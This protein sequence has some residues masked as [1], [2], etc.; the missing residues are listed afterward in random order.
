MVAVALALA[1]AGCT[2]SDEHA[3]NLTAGTPTEQVEAI[4]YFTESEPPG[5]VRS[6]FRELLL[7]VAEGAP[8]G[9]GRSAALQVMGEKKDPAFLEALLSALED[10]SFIVRYRAAEALGKYGDPAAVEPLAQ[11]LED[12]RHDW[13]RMEAAQA[14]T[15][16]GDH[17]AIE[18]LIHALDED[19]P[20]PVRFDAYLGLKALTG[21][22]LD[23]RR[24]T[25]VEWW[26][27][28][29][30]RR[31]PPLRAAPESEHVPEPDSGKNE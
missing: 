20:A 13:V 5:E 23:R 8:S 17:R 18:P 14:L 24:E 30:R 7:R 26:E 31:Y 29:G 12:D 27:K 16:I 25:W 2:S 15:L 19:N 21:L 4:H 3:A 1:T 9:A 6:E 11:V 22:A 10:P 28:E